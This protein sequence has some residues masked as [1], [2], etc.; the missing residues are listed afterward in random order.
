MYPGGIQSSS[1]LVTAVKF[2][3][4]AFKWGFSR[5]DADE[6]V[7]SPVTFMYKMTASKRGNDR[8]MYVGKTSAGVV[9]AVG[10]EE[11]EDDDYVFHMQ[12]AT[13]ADRREAN[14]YE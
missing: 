7:G 12:S 11:Q 8:V 9:I 2:R 3:E 14:Y 6:V 13:K 4:S 10:I 1:A 5:A